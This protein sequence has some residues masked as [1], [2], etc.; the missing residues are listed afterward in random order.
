MN[1][2]IVHIISMQSQTSRVVR[3]MS[4][5]VGETGVMLIAKNLKPAGS[6]VAGRALYGCFNAELVFDRTIFRGMGQMLTKG[7][8]VGTLGGDRTVMPRSYVI[9]GGQMKDTSID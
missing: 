2:R 8:P 1:V 4:T 3:T 6:S 5:S 9:V 7:V